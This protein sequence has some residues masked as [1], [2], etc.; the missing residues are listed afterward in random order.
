M[1]VSK[2]PKEQE[3]RRKDPDAPP[4]ESK[5]TTKNGLNIGWFNNV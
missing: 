3:V 4:E 5:E 1:Q 2:D